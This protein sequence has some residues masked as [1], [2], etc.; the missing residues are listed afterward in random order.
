MRLTSSPSLGPSLVMSGKRAQ[1]RCL[2]YLFGSPARAHAAGATVEAVVE[3]SRLTHTVEERNLNGFGWVTKEEFMTRF[4]AR[5]PY[6]TYA[7]F[8]P[9]DLRGEPLTVAARLAL[10][11]HPLSGAQWQYCPFTLLSKY[12]PFSLHKPCGLRL[13]RS[14]TA[15]DLQAPIDPGVPEGECEGCLYPAISAGLPAPRLVLY[16]GTALSALRCAPLYLSGGT[17]LQVP[18]ASQ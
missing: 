4:A 13:E 15:G 3:S 12:R 6:V 10:R 8:G 1:Y 2:S 16:L 5:P 9:D 11:A 17:P 18:T 7:P 14:P